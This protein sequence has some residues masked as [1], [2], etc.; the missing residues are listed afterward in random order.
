M[1]AANVLP[2]PVGEARSRFFPAA[3]NGHD[4]ACAGVGS[5]NRFANHS[6]TRLRPICGAVDFRFRAVEELKGPP[7]YA[8][9]LAAKL[10]LAIPWDAYFRRSLW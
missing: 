3:I 5:P 8:S 7:R 4:C 1:K 9:L 10:I 6:K 2:V